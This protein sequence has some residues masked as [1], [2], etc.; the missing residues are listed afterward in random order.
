[1]GSHEHSPA[2]V[3]PASLEQARNMWSGFTKA[4][5]L[6]VGHIIVLLLLMAIFLL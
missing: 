2:D 1:M 5:V 6:A 4:T 3:D